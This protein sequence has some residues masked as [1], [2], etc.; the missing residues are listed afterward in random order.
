MAAASIGCGLF[1]IVKSAGNFKD[2]VKIKMPVQL[3]Y[4]H[5][6]FQI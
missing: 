1:V 6:Y 2:I 3:L 4:G 5:F